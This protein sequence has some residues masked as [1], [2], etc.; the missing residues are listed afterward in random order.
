M[1]VATSMTISN[2]FA[3]HRHVYTIY[4]F[5][6]DMDLKKDHRGFGRMKEEKNDII[7]VQSSKIKLITSFLKKR[8]HSWFPNR[9]YCWA[10]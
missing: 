2:M 1:C 8:K 10:S 7:V 6:K 3:L 4:I 9:K 5:K